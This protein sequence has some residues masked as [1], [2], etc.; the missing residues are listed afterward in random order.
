MKKRILIA[1]ILVLLLVSMLPIM[2]ASALIGPQYVSTSNGKGLNMRSGPS[3]DFSV[4]TTIPYGAM[5]D[6]TDYYD[7]AWSY[8][9]YKGFAGYVMSR[10][11]SSTPPT[12]KPSPTP[13]PSPSDGISYK[14]FEKADY[15]VTVRPSTPSGFVN[16]RW[17]PS[18]SV[19]VYTIFYAGS[20]LHVLSQDKTWAQVIDESTG[21][22]GFM[23]R[24]F[25][26]DAGDG[27]GG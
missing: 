8:V 22:C 25:L 14:S 7:S 17:A 24:N 19:Q 15:H 3:K 1:L 9:T 2:G 16:L 10:Y 20:L 21:T 13:T 4:V 11:L 26:T 12:S 23:M 18:K 27:S 6:S 5:M